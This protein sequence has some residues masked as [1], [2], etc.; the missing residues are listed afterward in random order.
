[1]FPTQVGQHALDSRARLEGQQEVCVWGMGR[2][3][4]R[5]VRL[6]RQERQGWRMQS[7]M[8]VDGSF[9]WLQVERLAED[10]P[11]DGGVRLLKW[12]R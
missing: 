2:R 5:G 6:E 4:W 1:M 7:L 11:R 12:S 10:K 8:R 3:V 9:L